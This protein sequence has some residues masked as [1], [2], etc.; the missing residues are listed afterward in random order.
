MMKM[1]YFSGALFLFNFFFVMSVNHI[2]IKSMT[3]VSSD[4][5]VFPHYHYFCSVSSSNFQRVNF[6]FVLQLGLQEYL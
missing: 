5:S 1:K 3:W 6:L 4:A 2:Q